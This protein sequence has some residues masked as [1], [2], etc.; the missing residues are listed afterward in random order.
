MAR[1]K[2]S[3][4]FLALAGL[5]V[6]AGLL[7]IGLALALPRVIKWD[8]AGYLNL[9]RNLLTGKGFIGW[10]YPEVHHPPLYPVI[11][12]A[13]YLLV[14]DF[15]LASNLAH[16]LFGGLLLVPVFAIARHIYGLQTA[17]L[18]TVL[19]AIFP[20]LTV[21][22]LYWGAMIEP[23]YLCLLYGGLAAL[24]MG[25]ESG[26]VGMFAVAGGLFGLAYLTRPE[27]IVYF[28]VFLILGMVWPALKMT[29]TNELCRVPELVPLAPL[30]VLTAWRPLGWFILI[31]V[32]LAA[33]YVWYL[34]LQTGQWMLSGK[35]GITWEVGDAMIA[36]D[37]VAFD[38]LNTGLDSSGQELFWFS[39]D[40]FKHSHSLTGRILMNPMSVVHRVRANVSEFENQFF[41][42]FWFGLLPLVALGLFKKPWDRRCLRHEVF[43]IS[44]IIVLLMV[45]LPFGVLVRYFAPAF[46][47]LLM[48]TARGALELGVW[49]QDTLE[50][51]LRRPASCRTFRS[52][53][54]WLPAGIVVLFLLKGVYAAA[55]D[56]PHATFF[57]YKEAGLWLR[58]HTQV[59]AAVMTSE[60]GTAL[61]AD[62]RW[63]PSP[64]TD[65][66]RFLG[67]ARAHDANYLVVYE[68]ELKARPHLAFLFE[69]GDP[70]LE[71]VFSFEETSLA[72][73]RTFRTL[74]YC[75]SPK[76]K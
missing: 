10:L 34:H 19:L 67:Y 1:N 23:L 28:G 32:L 51:C 39:P 40:R 41:S 65:W 54:G 66:A 42:V 52:M 59:G 74:V 30:R 20:A 24:L 56:G 72:R 53:V 31:F 12:G 17:W 60:L 11:S 8:E 50:L 68:W 25:L 73:R 58:T 46:P 14:R 27:A 38:R 43:L 63:V 44:I 9:G 49:L 57:G 48:W 70:E 18:A 22:V 13:L 2:C 71:L 75:I 16:A 33:P 4:I 36:H 3:T 15:E 55:Q 61:Y 76:P 35:M 29:G 37:A 5:V 62:R 45:F 47:V 26:R 7:R 64:H 21:S 6:G 69:T